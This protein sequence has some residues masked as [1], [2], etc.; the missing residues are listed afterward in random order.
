[1]TDQPLTP[2]EQVRRLYEE[3]EERTS[4]AL[5]DLVASEGF[6]EILAMVTAN[7]MAV[8]KIA[9][10]GLDTVVRA[11]RLAGRNDIA[12][13]GRQQARTEDKLEYLLQM[14]EKL[15]QRLEAADDGGVVPASSGSS[16]RSRSRGSAGGPQESQ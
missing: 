10:E 12:R 11:M 15:E 5:E 6:G 2:A 7:S 9:S 4:T 13:L 16:G 14:V 3:A 8:I 1:M